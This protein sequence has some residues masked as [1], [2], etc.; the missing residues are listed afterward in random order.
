VSKCVCV[1]E[2]EEKGESSVCGVFNESQV[3]SIVAV[4]GLGLGLWI[5]GRGG[6]TG[7]TGGREVC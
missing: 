5:V 4:L 6:G 2:C 1:C 3:H 7:T